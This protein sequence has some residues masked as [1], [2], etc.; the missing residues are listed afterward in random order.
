MTANAVEL[1]LMETFHRSFLE[2]LQLPMRSKRAEACNTLQCI[3]LSTEARPKKYL[4]LLPFKL[5][6]EEVFWTLF[7][8]LLGPGEV[9]YSIVTPRAGGRR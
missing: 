5:W 1:C 8:V 2:L 6:L 7:C 9:Q 4:H 3:K